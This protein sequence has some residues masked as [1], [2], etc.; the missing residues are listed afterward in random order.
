[1]SKLPTQ[2]RWKLFVGALDVL[3]YKE[4]PPSPGAARHF[5]RGNEDPVTFHEPHGKP[6]KQGTLSEYLRKLGIDRETF[7][8][9]LAGTSEVAVIIANEESFRRTAL[10]NGV[11]ASNCL[12]CCELV[13]TGPEA[14]VTAAEAAHVCPHAASLG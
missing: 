8:A 5:Q 3:R 14:E 6:L 2:L 9:A 13:A 12:N 7:M 4:L 1:L 11:F 10:A